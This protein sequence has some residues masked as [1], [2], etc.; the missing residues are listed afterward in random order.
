MPDAH[1][2]TVKIV[3]A[4]KAVQPSQD[5]LRRMASAS[6]SPRSQTA[7]NVVRAWQRADQPLRIGDLQRPRHAHSGRRLGGQGG[8][9]RPASLP[10]RF[11]LGQR[12]R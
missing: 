6:R 4:S 1:L 12:R 7:R 2:H 8:R 9:S 11:G 3:R 5:V 10:D